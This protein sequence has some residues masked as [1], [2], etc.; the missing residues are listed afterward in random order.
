MK[1]D[2]W[3]QKWHEEFGEFSHKYLKV[4]L[5]KSSVMF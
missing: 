4:M 3:F 2:L 1:N 5:N